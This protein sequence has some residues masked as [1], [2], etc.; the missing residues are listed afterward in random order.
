LHCK[1]GGEPEQMKQRA[2]IKP[3]SESLEG[4][5]SGAADL[6]DLVEKFGARGGRASRIETQPA[7]QEWIYI[8][9]QILLRSDANHGYGYALL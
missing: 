6:L 4:L 5:Q 1:Q 2:E 3:D 8:A 9:R 7:C